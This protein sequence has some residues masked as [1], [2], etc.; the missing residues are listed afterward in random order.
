MA[1]NNTI[2]YIHKKDILGFKKAIGDALHNKAASILENKK[3]TTL[4][5]LFLSNINESVEKELE[6]ILSSNAR[7][8]IKFQSGETMVVDLQTAN[9]VLTVLKAIKKPELAKKAVE[10]LNKNRAS[11]LKFL[12]FA[13]KQIK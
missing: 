8:T 6:G 9:V 1:G 5:S 13:W 10:M 11:F 3:R 4:N 7:R 2:K 12:D